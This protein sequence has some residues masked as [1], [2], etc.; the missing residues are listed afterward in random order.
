MIAEVGRKWIW[1]STH[2]DH[3]AN[4]IEKTPAHHQEDSA[5]PSCSAIG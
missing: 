2:E 5:I 4:G 1:L 3:R